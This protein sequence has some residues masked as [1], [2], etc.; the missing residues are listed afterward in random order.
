MAEKS[1]RVS[2]SKEGYGCQYESH[3]RGDCFNARVWELEKEILSKILK[4][5]FSQKRIENYLDFA[6]GTGRIC[7]FMESRVE[8]CVGV[9][10]TTEMIDIARRNCSRTEFVVA[11]ITKKNPF[12][13][14]N[15]DLITAFRFFLNAESELR[16]SVLCELSKTISENGLFIFNVHGNKNSLR[17]LAIIFSRFLGIKTN[18]NELSIDE[19]KQM[20]EN[21]NFRIRNYYGVNYLPQ[22]ASSIIPRKLWMLAEKINNKFVPKGLALNIIIIAELNEKKNSHN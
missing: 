2:H 12:G 1:Y 13:T 5:Y 4:K 7:Q 6:C 15:F 22:V 9:D 14:G 8:K 19:V 18:T 20:L 3:F 16:K 17:H 10:I 11:D 21:Y